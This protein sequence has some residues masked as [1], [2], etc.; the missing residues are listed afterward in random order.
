MAG[1]QRQITTSTIF[2][3]MGIVTIYKGHRQGFIGPDLE[4]IFRVSTF[5]GRYVKLVSEAIV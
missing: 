4:Q 5:I 3:P 2:G 1:G